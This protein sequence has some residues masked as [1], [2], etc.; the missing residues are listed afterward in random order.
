MPESASIIRG[1]RLSAAQ[2]PKWIR[3][4]D[5][6]LQAGVGDVGIN[7]SRRDAAVSEEALYETNVDTFLEQQRRGGVAEP[8]RCKMRREFEIV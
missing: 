2:F 4:L 8:V 5:H 3:A 1:H 6:S 7:F